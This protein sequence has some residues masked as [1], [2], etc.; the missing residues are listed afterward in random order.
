MAHRKILLLTKLGG[1][2]MISFIHLSDIHFT[3]Y[4]GDQ[5]DA[6]NDLRNEIILDIRHNFVGNINNPQGILIC[7]DIA[8]SGQE[9]EYNTASQFINEICDIIDIPHCSVFCVPGNHDVDQSIP[10]S[11]LA[12]KILQDDLASTQ[13][14]A[15]FNERLANLFRDN[16]SAKMLYAPIYHYNI[17]ATQYKCHLNTTPH[18]QNWQE[19]IQL[20]DTY[21]L[22]IVGLNSTIISNADDHLTENERLMKM[23]SLQIPTRAD[24]T[25]FLTLCH[26]P[27]ESWDDTNQTVQNILDERIQLQ[28]YGHKHTQVIKKKSKTVIVHSGATHPSRLEKDWIPRYNWISLDINSKNGYDYLSIII[29]PRIYNSHIGKFEKDISLVNE[30]MSVEFTLLLGHNTQQ[31][32]IVNAVNEVSYNTNNHNSRIEWSKQFAYDFINLPLE[33]QREI[34]T[35]L[36]LYRNEDTNKLHSEILIDIVNRAEEYQCIE[37]LIEEV[38]KYKR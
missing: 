34:L 25:V 4:S 15:Q 13:D 11:K 19:Y 33:R 37:A 3:K 35:K 8:F 16:E 26:H 38:N 29:Y 17:F 12:V 28:L 27:P 31:T 18:R 32:N 1:N 5:F 21:K 10:K 14:E 20:T 23:S 6:D 36:N 7:G 9:K 2:Y 22:C 24:N 30:D